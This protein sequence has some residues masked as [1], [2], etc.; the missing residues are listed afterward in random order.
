MTTTAYVPGTTISYVPDEA[1]FQ[2][3]PPR[4]DGLDFNWHETWLY[5]TAKGEFYLSGYGNAYSMWGWGGN[6]GY[7]TKPL[8]PLEARRL[9]EEHWR[10]DLIEKYLEG[11]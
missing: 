5:R 2:L 10:H 6:P 8:T 9:L 7:G 4:N 1:I 3:L 11:V